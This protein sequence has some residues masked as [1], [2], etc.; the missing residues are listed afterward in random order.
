MESTYAVFVRPTFGREWLYAE[1]RS[2]G[3]SE[4]QLAAAKAEGFSS[5]RVVDLRQPIDWR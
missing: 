3:Q 4:Q 5:A 2:L 1:A